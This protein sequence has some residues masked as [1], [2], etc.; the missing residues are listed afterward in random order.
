MSAILVPTLTGGASATVITGGIGTAILKL[1]KR[2]AADAVRE[3]TQDIA[4]EVNGL[5]E[6]LTTVRE[7]VAYLKGV[8]QNGQPKQPGAAA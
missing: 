8:T 2:V 5:R 3:G 4:D 1:L 7:D 6:D